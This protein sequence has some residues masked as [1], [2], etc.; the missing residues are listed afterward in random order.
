MRLIKEVFR[1]VRRFPGVTLLSVITI[2]LTLYISGLFGLLYVNITG[3]LSRIGERIQMVVFVRD[4]APHDA[5]EALRQGLLALDGVRE[6]AYMSKGEALERFRKELG[7]SA[8]LL[9]D[10]EENPLP[11]SF[12]IT[13]RED[14]RDGTYLQSIA[15]E[16]EAMDTVEMVDYA[17]PWTEEFDRVRKLI[18][19]V[20]LVTGIVV[21]M[22]SVLII[23]FSIRLALAS[24]QEE[25]SVIHLVGATDLYLSKPYL[26]EGFLKGVA[27]GALALLF[28]TMTR[29][30][31]TTGL[32][33]VSFFTE[34]QVALGILAG[35]LIGT[36]GALL[37][38]RSFLKTLLVAVLLL[39]PLAGTPPPL[40]AQAKDTTG[41]TGDIEQGKS[42][43]EKIRQ[44]IKKNRA[45][46][47][48]LKSKEA[49]VTGE[50]QHI[51][52]EI[53]LR[54]KLV[55]KL[56]KEL[57]SEEE[58]L[59]VI[60][61]ELETTQSRLDRR[62]EILKRRLRSV[63]ERGL[64]GLLEVALSSNA[65]PR[66][67]LRLEYLSR[68]L[69]YD[70][71]VVEDISQLKA[72]IEREEREKEA[73]IQSIEGR[74]REVDREKRSLESTSQDKKKLLTSVRNEKKKREK[75]IAELVAQEKSLQALIQRLEEERLLAEK[76]G[77]GKAGPIAGLYGKLPWPVRGEVITKF[78]TNYDPIYKTKIPSQ[79]IDIAAGLGTP[80]KAVEA[81]K[82]EY[83]DWW[84]AYGKMI[85]INHGGGYYTLYAHMDDISVAA[86]IQVARQQV[87]GKVGNTGS[88]SNPSLHF[89]LRR[90]KEAL[91]PLMWLQAVGG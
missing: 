62:E 22:A 90:G 17:K 20:G 69:A 5:V 85:I 43:L 61:A 48:K 71:A 27:G 64:P 18:G 47:E 87:I 53:D 19:L 84:Q 75:M 4:E 54:G 45:E 1:D 38:V 80:V 32:Y 46:A 13:F 86:G 3:A 6:V 65:L 73:K 58:D 26:L 14:R 30:L 59:G 25:M 82:V 37:S 39:L 41:V 42:D 35:G 67:G 28:L 76:A 44:E 66:L 70:R 63:Y 11:A 91:D 2:T 24:K 57:T 10:L 7:E 74:K 88:L 36:A 51:N 15:S 33:P 34:G 68:V 83:A 52:K 23:S 50:L 31:V 79:G 56:G 29:R 89:E 49:S 40:H 55:S 72:D 60:A 8:S 12:E 78:G 81:G 77:R 16:L 9:D 21:V